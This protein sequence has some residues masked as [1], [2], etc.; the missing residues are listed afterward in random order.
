M[1]RIG[2]LVTTKRRVAAV[3]EDP[4][5]DR[6]LECAIEAKSDYIGSGDKDLLRV[7]QFEGIQITTVSGFLSSLE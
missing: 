3:P 6:I 5:D 1:R 4:D 7:G 2:R